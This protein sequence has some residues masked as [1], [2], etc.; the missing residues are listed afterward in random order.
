[1]IESVVLPVIVIT[2]GLTIVSLILIVL[3]ELLK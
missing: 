3:W 1:M 2:S